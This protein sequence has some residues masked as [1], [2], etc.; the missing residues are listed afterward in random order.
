MNIYVFN[1]KDYV[2]ILSPYDIS[3]LYAEM[4]E[5]FGIKVLVV[6][7]MRMAV[8]KAANVPL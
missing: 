1:C 6:L 5:L 2:P 4:A 7:W 8:D 3:V